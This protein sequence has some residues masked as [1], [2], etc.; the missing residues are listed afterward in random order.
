MFITNQ[1]IMP[2]YCKGEHETKVR[3]NYN[4]EGKPPA[5]CV[6]CKTDEMINVGSSASKCA[7]IDPETGKQCIKQPSFN[8]EGKM[9]ATHCDTHK[10][11]E[12]VYT[13][14]KKC[15]KCNKDTA[16]YAVNGKKVPTHC[17]KC[18]DDD[19][20]T[21]QGKKCY[22]CSKSSGF[23]NVD[24]TLWACGEH[25][26]NDDFINPSARYCDEGCGTRASFGPANGK[27]KYCGTHKDNEPDMINLVLL[28]KKSPTLTTEDV[29]SGQETLIENKSPVPK[30]I[31]KRK[32]VA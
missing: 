28:G 12:M 3:A 21:T 1:T 31:F 16:K 24:K 4:L 9:K 17:F 18:K 11:P 7:H 8:F 23:C 15:Q 14:A 30:I 2:S 10:D 25:A 26:I 13:R 22:A 27:P 6:S 29:I 19:M 32:L 20:A 5:Y